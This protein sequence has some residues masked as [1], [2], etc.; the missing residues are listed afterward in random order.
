MNLSTSNAQL[1]R[2]VGHGRESMLHRAG[3]VALGLLF[4]IRG[5]LVLF[6]VML[7]DVLGF[8]RS[9]NAVRCVCGEHDLRTHTIAP[10][11]RRDFANGCASCVI[12]VPDEASRMAARQR[13]H[14]DFPRS[15]WTRIGILT[16]AEC[17]R[18]L[19]KQPAETVDALAATLGVPTHA[20]LPLR[21][22][23]SHKQKRNIAL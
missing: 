18:Q 11:V 20:W 2:V 5:F 21:Q 7:T 19:S 1:Q 14:R 6:E 23:K 3:K 9:G 10:N 22:T 17:C 4:A 8:R 12:L 16:H 13:L 15:V